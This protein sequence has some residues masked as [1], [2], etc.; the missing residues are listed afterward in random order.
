MLSRVA[1]SIYWAGRYI[2]RAENTARFIDVN[3]QMGLD[4]PS[5]FAEQWAPMVAILGSN[6]GFADRY[7]EASREN[8]IEF[9]AADP[10]NSSSILSCLQKARENARSVREVISSEMWEQINRYYLT[11]SNGA[12]RRRPSLDPYQFFNEVKLLSQQVAGVSDNTMSHDQAWHFFQVG[13]LLERADNTSRLLDVKYFLLL[14]SVEDVGGAVDEMQWSILLRS[15]S[16]FEMYRK[17]YGRIDPHDVVEFLLLDKDFPRAIFFC[18]DRGEE[19]LRAISG[20]ERG[21]FS[22]PAEQRMGLLRSELAYSQAYDILA[23][24]LHEF[25]D[26]L[27]TKLNAVGTAIFDTYFALRTAKAGGTSSDVLSG[28]QSQRGPGWNR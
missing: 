28:Y 14:P 17:R 18:V 27:Q 10:L 22:N 19:F 16:A 1:E 21:R 15:A 4:A 23:A 26:G 7:D 3:L 6:S 8:V 5:S 12:A 20:V 9:L 2:E 11:V 24:G 13:R 25:L